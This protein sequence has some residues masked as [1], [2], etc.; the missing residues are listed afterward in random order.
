M[1][2]SNTPKPTLLEAVTEQY[3]WPCRKHSLA[4]ACQEYAKQEINYLSNYELLT[5]IS[6]A[7]EELNKPT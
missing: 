1:P 6:R 2:D 3:A 7:L 4:P 5:A